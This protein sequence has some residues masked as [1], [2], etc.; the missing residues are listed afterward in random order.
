MEKLG[1]YKRDILVS[2]VQ[3]ARDSQQEAKEQF[4]SALEKF[5]SVINFRGGALQE[6]YDQLKAELDASEA[7]A[8]V[9][10]Q[11]ITAVADVA[12]ALFDEW[13][14][15]LA[16]YSNEQLRRAS[17][18]QLAQTRQR[19]Q[20]LMGAMQ[21]AEA[22]IEPVLAV[23]RDQVLFLKHNL[24]AQA[25]ASLQQEVTTVEANVA[26]L[27]RDMEASIA[28]ADTFLKAMAEPAPPTS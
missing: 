15:E 12:E 9:V 2:R 27:I 5:S 6:K 18:R 1:Y 13:Q 21:R 8:Q 28:E 10:H 17:R 20:P 3:D 23:F 26:S 24:N 16:Q 11:R 25:I 14:A 22:K 4:R 19:Y 7:Q